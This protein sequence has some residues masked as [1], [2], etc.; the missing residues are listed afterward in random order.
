MMKQFWLESGC[1]YGYRKV[2][3]DLRDLSES[4]GINQVY[5]LMRSAGL[6]AQVG[7][8]EPRYRKGDSHFIT[9]NRLQRQ[10]N[11]IVLDEV[12]VTDITYIR[13]Y[14]Y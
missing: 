14:E 10:F 11:P 2:H 1:V 7:Y 5:R 6:K 9:P 4:C 13:T 3:S 12:W 8:R